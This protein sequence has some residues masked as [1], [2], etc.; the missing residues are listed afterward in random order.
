MSTAQRDAI[1]SPTAGMIIY[2]TTTLGFDLYTTT[3]GSASKPHVGVFTRDQAGAAGNVS[4]TGVGFKPSAIS[5][6]ANINNQTGRSIGFDNGVVRYCSAEATNGTN[7]AF[8]SDSI[9]LLDNS[10]WSQ[11]GMV[12]SFDSDGFTITW[13]IGGAGSAGTMQIYFTAFR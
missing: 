1:A 8:T 7:R 6:I 4:Y 12:A 2:N 5:F 9:V 13:T 11:Q 10:S 3:W